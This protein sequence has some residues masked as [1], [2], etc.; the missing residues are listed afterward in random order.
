MPT[1]ASSNRLTDLGMSCGSRRASKPSQTSLSTGKNQESAALVSYLCM[2][3]NLQ[4]FNFPEERFQHTI[5]GVGGRVCLQWRW[6]LRETFPFPPTVGGGEG[7]YG[8]FFLGEKDS[9]KCECLVIPAVQG[10]TGEI[11]FSPA[12][13]SLLKWDLHDW[14][15]GGDWGRGRE[16]TSFLLN[17]L[18]RKFTQKPQRLLHQESLY[19]FPGCLQ[20][21]KG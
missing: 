2:K 4:K 15:E 7:Q 3:E 19:Q 14:G 21:P 16:G 13:T 9:S 6:W 5:L 18:S 1:C 20:S 11:H 17:A 8:D 10:V 12:A